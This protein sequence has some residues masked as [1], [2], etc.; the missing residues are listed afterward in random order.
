MS[1]IADRLAAMA[2][3][4]RLY[5]LRTLPAHLAGA[6][7]DDRLRRVLTN[8]G[9]LGAKLETVGPE[10][11]I[12]DY[13]LIAGE[14]LGLDLVQ[15]AIRL[16]AHVLRADP[17]LLYGQLAARLDGIGAAAVT[18]LLGA[19]PGT[20][21]LRPATRSLVLASAPLLRTLTG[22][23]ADVGEIV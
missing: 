13:G 15:A 8:L 14:P 12:A 22:H 5:A 10:P 18:D 16:A 9:F 19:A 17:R 21:W 2:P 6:G 20:P 3:E 11:L 4:D 23:T 1:D 7:R